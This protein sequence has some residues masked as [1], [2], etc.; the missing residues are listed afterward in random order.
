[1]GTETEER[2]SQT[3]AT[4][5]RMDYVVADIVNLSKYTSPADIGGKHHIKA[6]REILL[7]IKD[8]Q[9]AKR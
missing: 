2:Q 8:E 6:L 1:M 9:R 5:R 3:A 4:E 7:R